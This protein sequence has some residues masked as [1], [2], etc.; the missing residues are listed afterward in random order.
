MDLAHTETI[1][2]RDVITYLRLRNSGYTTLWCGEGLI[3]MQ[4]PHGDNAQEVSK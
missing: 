1:P 3:C 4:A 2:A